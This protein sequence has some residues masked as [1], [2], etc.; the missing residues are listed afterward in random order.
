MNITRTLAGLCLIWGCQ[1]K[2]DKKSE[3]DFKTELKKPLTEISGLIAD[4]DDL[5]AIT[6]KPKANFYKLSNK[7]ELKQEVKVKNAEAID[8]E[9]VTADENFIYIGDVG[10]NDGGREERQVIKAKKSAIGSGK[11]VE[12]DGEIITFTFSDQ[13][14]VE[15]K[16]KNNYDCEAVLSLGDS[17]YL[18]TKRREDQQTELFS[19]PKSA[20][21]HVANSLG[22]FDCKGLV[23]DAAINKSKNEIALCGYLKGHKFPFILLFK[24]FSGNNF[25]LGTT[26]R[27]ELTDKAWDWQVEAITYDDKG[28][29]YFACEETKEV[30]STFYVIKRD[31]LPKLNKK[32]N[33]E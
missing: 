12:I 29:L 20:G 21:T 18:F 26:E 7:G 25:F 14:T 4:G 8:V 13:Q 16:K 19:L 30:K 15:K 32:R 33:D 2:S 5:W 28:N 17:L 9:A 27:I 10:D 6:D 24:N 1:A 11:E 22:I 31:K 23:T 3:L